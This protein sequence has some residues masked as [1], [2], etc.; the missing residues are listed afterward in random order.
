MKHDAVKKAL[1]REVTSRAGVVVCL[2]GPWGCGKTH[3]WKEV[4][5]E[6]GEESHVVYVSLFGL[7]SVSEAKSA[8]VNELVFGAEDSASQSDFVTTAGRW[9]VRQLPTFTKVL[10]ARLGLELLTKNLDLT[11]LLPTGAVICLDDLER[12]SDELRLQDALGLANLL[13]EQRGAI[14]VV[15]MNE[16]H[17][18][19][20][21]PDQAVT[22]KNYRERVAKRFLRVEADLKAVAPHLI[23]Q[24]KLPVTPEAAQLVTET[25]VSAKSKN[26]RTLL[27]ALD[28]CGVA[29]AALSPAQ[30]S[31]ND[32]RT[33]TAL[34]SEHA[35]GTLEEKGFYEFDPIALAF[36]RREPTPL[37]EKRQTFFDRYFGSSAYSFNSVLY[38]F[39]ADGYLDAE[40]LKGFL[41]KFE[42]DT[43]PVGRLLRRI[44]ERDFNFLSDAESQN[45]INDTKRIIA[46]E[47]E[48]LTARLTVRLLVVAIVVAETAAITLP[49]D[50]LDCTESALVDA[51]RR[52]DRSLEQSERYSSDSKLI[53]TALLDTYDR[54]LAVE[55]GRRLRDQV[56]AAILA[57]DAKKLYDAIHSDLPLSAEAF[58]EPELLVELHALRLKDRRTY[59]S[60]IEELA[61]ITTTPKGARV[62]SMLRSYL[63]VMLGYEQVDVSDRSRVLRLVSV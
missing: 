47:H 15:I 38:D 17:I 10:D 32:V 2:T 27:R 24:N 1:Q 8:I 56:M 57:R 59:F 45:W 20:R 26:V 29:D 37:D 28:N 3:L 41:K 42:P 31:E 13:A 49:Q 12:A 62:E 50:L 36:A 34:T 39:V 9:I 52:M 55:A 23:E 53:P 63:G 60:V 33:L 11:R 19:E 51:A 22:L 44:D 54:E 4:A 18:A 25:L 6:F 61:E 21:F 7:T 48:R 5:T 43:S 30:L 46:E 40:R 58:L 16:D 14:V 35:Q